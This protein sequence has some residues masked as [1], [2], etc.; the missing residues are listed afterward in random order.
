MEPMQGQMD[1]WHSI[2]LI[3]VNTIIWQIFQYIWPLVANYLGYFFSFFHHFFCGY[4]L[5]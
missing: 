4:S 2:Q 1:N 3:K 5:L